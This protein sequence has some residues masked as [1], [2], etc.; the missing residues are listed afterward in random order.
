MTEEQD[1]NLETEIVSENPENITEID[2]SLQYEEEIATLKDQYLRSI[3]EAENLRTRFKRENEETAKY[4]TTKFARDMV[5]VLENLTRASSS[6]SEEARNSSEVVKQVAEGIDMTITQLTGIF[7]RNGI[8]RID[9][10]GEKFD[11][12]L[13]Q[14]VTTVENKDVAAG[15][16]LQVLQAGYV[17]HD[18]LLRAAMVA[19]SA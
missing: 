2:K 16:V 18:R 6:I 4:A 9:P 12:S 7:E 15:T 1:S 3:A 10:V 5:D 11:H 19:V 13:H 17:L 8:K 14:A